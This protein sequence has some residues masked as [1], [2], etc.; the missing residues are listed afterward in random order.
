[1]NMHTLSKLDTERFRKV[2]TLIL[3]G[4]TAGERA[5]AKARAEAMAMKSGMT[6]AQAVSMLDASPE[7][8]DREIA[9]RTGVSP[10]TVNNWRHRHA[11]A[12][13]SAA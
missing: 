5:A 2:H 1:M 13:R 8:A 9:R 11:R 6:F 10:Q 12:N 3:K 7:L 4:A